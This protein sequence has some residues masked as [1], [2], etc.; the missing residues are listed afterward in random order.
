M[1]ERHRRDAAARSMRQHHDAIALAERP[2]HG[3][4]TVS[5]RPRGQRV[6]LGLA[7]LL[8]LEIASALALVVLA[9]RLPD[10]FWLGRAFFLGRVADV[11]EA[12]LRGHTTYPGY[13]A[14]L[15]WR[16]APDRAQELV[17]SAG[18]AWTLTHDADGARRDLV[19]G[20]DAPLVA[21]F[22]DSFTQCDEV[23]DDATWQH[24]LAS[25]LGVPVRN[26]GVG[27][28]GTDQA[29]LLLER[30]LD[31]GLRVPVLVLG[32]HEENVNRV[33]N[34]YRPFYAPADPLIF[35][36]K[37]RFLLDGDRLT[38]LPSPLASDD[39]PLQPID[40]YLD[41]ATQHDHWYAL[42]A[43]R[44][45]VAFPFSYQ[46]AK[47]G[48]DVAHQRGVIA[49]NPLAPLSRHLWQQADARRLMTAL[50]RRFVERARA[51]GATPVLLLIPDLR[52]AASW[53]ADATGYR[54]WLDDLHA[55]FGDTLRVVDVAPAIDDPRAF[56][57]QPHAGHASPDGNR[58]IARALEPVL[59][60]LLRGAQAS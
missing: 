41:A 35:G 31:A 8:A 43:Q 33:V 40:A 56:R 23:D 3:E 32:V 29:L 53:S 47:L 44:P 6:A 30:H 12:R 54:D 52:D 2:G 4:I 50:V 60:S 59:R 19:F 27:A 15:G 38:L 7:A 39:G 13:D 55:T 42:D 34:R 26:F 28:Y 17:N 10:H 16:N 46:L 37:P 48:L 51:H 22:G 49:S 58:V 25:R 18:R 21:T 57:I 11:D 1:Q 14:V 9:S 45:R 5:S 24:E 20:S 36:F